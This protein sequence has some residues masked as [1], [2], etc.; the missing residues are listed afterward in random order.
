VR[1]RVADEDRL[2]PDKINA[3]APRPGFNL[4]G[5]GE[6]PA[7]P[8]EPGARDSPDARAL[9]TAAIAIQ[10]RI[11]PWASLDGKPPD[12]LGVAAVAGDLR[13][14]LDPEVTIAARA[15]G[16]VTRP[17][18][19]SPAD[20]LEPIMLAP[21]FPA[22]M[23]RPLRDLS[24]DLL[25]PGAEHLGANTIT[26]LESNNDFIESYM[27]GLNHEMGREL[28]W[29][30]Y[31]TD[32]RGTMF[33]QFWD[34]AGADPAT[35]REDLYDIDPIGGWDPA[36]PLGGNMR[37]DEEGQLVLLIRG[38][39]LGRYPNAAVSAVKATRTGTG[40]RQ[41]STEERFPIF[42][43]RLLPDILLLGFGLDRTE[44]LG[45]T[46]TSPEG[47]FFVLQQ[48]PTEPRFGLDVGDDADYGKTPTDWGNL[49]WKHF[50][51]S[52]STLAQLHHAPVSS[53]PP[54]GWTVGGVKWD[55]DAA[56]LAW[57][58]LQS[59]VRIAIHADDM[60]A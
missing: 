45:G 23:Y 58:T 52:K 47:W 13:V 14:H 54:T 18:G 12:P 16:R 24:Q 11:R 57:I 40:P 21:E 44:A 20:P 41:L 27:V 50:A 36:L 31:P 7:G 43:A 55:S 28:L 37:G 51:A 59:P 22:P 42:H 3:A 10:Q 8:A 4:L 49:S 35:P 9:R 32:Q 25:L 1:L 38:E 56:H 46:A 2:R 29:R 33:R 34:V 39:L 60:V 15:M 26:V 6:A 30:E 19:W 5:E 48:Q 17:S 53:G